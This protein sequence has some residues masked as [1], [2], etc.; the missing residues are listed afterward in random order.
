MAQANPALER[1]SSSSSCCSSGG[2]VPSNASLSSARMSLYSKM[3]AIVRR[4]EDQEDMGVPLRTVKSFLTKIPNVVT[5]SDILQ[6]LMKNLQ[7]DDQEALHL[8]SQIAA[9]GYYFPIADHVLSLKDDGTFYR[10]QNPYYWASNG[11]E[12]DNTDYAVYLCKRTMQNKARLELSDYESESLARMQKAF[13]RKWEF[14]FVQAE[15]QAKVDRKK[16]K[17]ERKITDGQERAFWDVHRIAPGCVSVMEEDIKKSCRPRSQK[18]ARKSVYG[19]QEDSDS[20]DCISN[21]SP[22]HDDVQSPTVGEMRRKIKFLQKQLDRHC[23]KV[24]KVAESQITYTEQYTEFDALVMA[25]GVTCPWIS[26]DTTFWNMDTSKEPSQS[27]VRRWG[28]SLDEVLK[29][30][31]GR[32]HFLKFLESEFSSENLQFWMA[33]QD[34]KRL[35]LQRTPQCVIE[36]WEEFLADGACNAI[37]LDSQTFEQ[38][39]QGLKEPNRYTFEEA[40]E[41]IFKLMKSDSYTRFLRS[42]DYQELLVKKKSE[43]DQDRRTSFEK[44]TRNVEMQFKPC[45]QKHSCSA[46]ACPTELEGEP[47]PLKGPGVK[48][49]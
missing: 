32:A 47:S 4:M 41:H 6:W 9:H 25:T 34:L 5:G 8:G 20:E 49:K 33:V 44:F 16:E 37:N 2:C 29:D 13:D 7:I 10:F 48:L 38:T 26:D 12:P 1:S 19:I 15:A 46:L 21:L 30:P 42:S 43:Q 24:S 14:I 23:L 31:L 11:W 17:T 35:P 40:Q 27:A 22:P 3:E 36:I 45:R 28:L 18:L 39:A